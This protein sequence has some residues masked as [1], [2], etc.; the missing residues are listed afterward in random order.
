MPAPSS[1]LFVTP[2]HSGFSR[3]SSSESGAD[4]SPL[5]ERFARLLTPLSVSWIWTTLAGR[6]GMASSSFGFDTGDSVWTAAVLTGDEGCSFSLRFEDRVL[7]LRGLLVLG[8]VA[9]SCG[10]AALRFCA[11]LVDLLGV[12]MGAASTEGSSNSMVVSTPMDAESAADGCLE[13]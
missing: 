13:L 4:S 5:D 8:E 11:C 7:L 6:A 2:F 9:S 1:K 10:S 3:S 12:S